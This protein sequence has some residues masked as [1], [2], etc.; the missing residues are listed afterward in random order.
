MGTGRGAFDVEVRA[1]ECTNCGAPLQ[2]PASGGT[3]S[4]TFC[5]TSNVVS[6]R[7]ADGGERPESAAEDVARLERL[8]A[9]VKSA[10]VDNPFDLSRPPTGVRPD[11]P[12]ETLRAEYE[13]RKAQPDLAQLVSS[14]HALCWLASTLAERSLTEGDALRARATL[15]TAL[16]HLPDPGHRHLIRCRLA[17]LAARDGELKAAE[18]WLAECDP[19][20]EVLAL[21][22]DYRLARAEVDLHRGSFSVALERIGDKLGKIPMMRTRERQ[23]EPLR[24]IAQ[25]RQGDLEGAETRLHALYYNDTMV[26]DVIRSS[27]LAP[28]LV[29][30]YEAVQQAVE[31]RLRIMAPLAWVFSGLAAALA[32]ALLYLHR[33]GTITQGSQAVVIFVVSVIPLSVGMGLGIGATQRKGGIWWGAIFLGLLALVPVG[34]LIALGIFGASL[35]TPDQQK[36]VWYRRRAEQPLFFG[37]I[38]VGI[39]LLGLATLTSQ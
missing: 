3:V 13:Q 23:S 2:A 28:E 11:A 5:G 19:A 36:G 14:Q 9:Q 8:A 39:L 6:V 4:C 22:T 15:E 18:G 27:G 37:L 10:V 38:L 24:I 12:T 34:G 33:T 17:V 26:L 35:L 25:Y 31:H 21:D 16:D 30:R 20:A 7:P 1:V 32:T 29:E